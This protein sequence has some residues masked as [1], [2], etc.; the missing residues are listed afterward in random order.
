MTSV[1]LRFRRQPLTQ[2][3]HLLFNEHDQAP[4][5]KDAVISADIAVP[6]FAW[7][8]GFTM[9]VAV[10]VEIALPAFGLEGQ[11]TYF[12]DTSRPLV[13][14]A[15]ARWQDA[16]IHKAYVELP[17]Q[18]SARAPGYFAAVYEDALPLRASMSVAWGETDRAQRPTLAS[19]Y[20]DGLQMHSYNEM[21]F[22][23]ARHSERP[24]AE[25][26]FQDAIGNAA[27]FE[28]RFQDALRGIAGEQASRFQDAK[29]FRKAVDQHFGT[30]REVHRAWA[31]RFQ[32]AWAP[33]PGRHDYTPRP[34]E[35][36][37]PCYVPSG[38]LVFSVPWS[39]NTALLFVCE[40][41][42]PGPDP[43]GTVIVPVRRIYTV[44][45]SA[46]LRRVDG[47][48]RIPCT[49]MSLSIDVDSWTW[50]FT[51]SVPGSALSDLEP[52]GVG[53]VEVAASINGV[54]YRAI[55][56]ER[57]RTRGFGASE[58]SIRGRGKAAVLDS[59]YSPMLTFSNTNARTVQQLANDVLSQNGVGLGWDIDA[60][61]QPDNWLVPAGA[62]SFQGSRMA[63][64]NAIAAAAGSYVQPHRTDKALSVLRRYPAAPWDWGKITPDFELPGGVVQNE[65]ATWIEKPVYNRVF[66]RGMRSGVLGQATRQGTAGDLEAPMVTD[67][68]IT[69]PVG[70]RQRAL[71]VLADVGQQA[72]MSL[73]LP[74][75][76][77]TGIIPP[78]KF[79]RYVDGGVTR[80]GLV[81][82]VA[83]EM[84][85]A[86]DK[87]T[88]WQT[89]GVET[90]VGL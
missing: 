46:S 66:V 57:S 49:S 52:R 58:L 90:H 71:P 38:D 56:E 41:H 8:G 61:W 9:G 48:V 78:G 15:D 37:K 24:G 88:I 27:K 2:P 77:E 44:I 79:V 85:R 42:G 14:Q 20:Q 89:I 80:I 29:A 21:A 74:V 35:P 70:A 4:V 11:V 50:G 18:D 86:D 7:T 17:W 84:R 25:E 32:D 87:L 36:P 62:W 30:G 64:L 3:A 59:P 55:V 63:A 19:R 53:P 22:S 10:D 81:R 31:S 83:A 16:L 33:T 54:E 73:R 67:Q 51:A 72:T 69:H 13:A 60:G 12:T 76:A 39:S 45:N 26:R 28:A 1:D 43:G 65:G 34:P 47:N 23:S 75:L 6:A 5:A 40:S 82:S 68:L